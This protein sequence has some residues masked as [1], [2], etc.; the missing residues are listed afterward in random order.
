MDRPP[1]GAIRNS[2]QAPKRP[3]PH[4]RRA[5]APDNR[6]VSLRSIRIGR[7]AGIP[8]GRA[9]VRTPDGRLDLL[10]ITDVRRVLRALE[11]AG[12]PSHAG[13]R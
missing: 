12:G 11:L 5:P 2:P 4:V 1:R 8:I 3:T 6:E 13:A 10:S 7:L 9:V